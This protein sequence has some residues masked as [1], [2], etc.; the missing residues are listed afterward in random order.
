M[1]IELVSIFIAG[2]APAFVGLLLGINKVADDSA[3]VR[4]PNSER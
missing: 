4:L 1:T 2:F 3:G